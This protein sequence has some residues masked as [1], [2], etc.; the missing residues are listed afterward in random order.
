MDNVK[1]LRESQVGEEGSGG[2]SGRPPG[3]PQ[4]RGFLLSR[5]VRGVSRGVSWT[6]GLRKLPQVL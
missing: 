1:S 5:E 4:A 3:Q 6:L 2:G